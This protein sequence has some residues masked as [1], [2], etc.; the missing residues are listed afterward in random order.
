MAKTALVV[1][2]FDGG[3]STDS[4]F[5][6][7]N[8]FFYSQHL[9]FRK[10]PGQMTVLPK[11]R[12]EAD[13]TVDDLVQNLVMVD[14]STIYGLGNTGLAYKRTTAGVWN[15]IGD[16]DNGA[17]GM[18]YR[19]DVDKLFLAS[20]KTISEYS[21][22]SNSPSIKVNKL[23]ASASTT[24]TRTSGT[25]TY[26]LKTAISESSS[27]RLSFTSDIEPMSSMKV[28]VAAKGTGNWTMTAH[29]E[30]NNTL[31]TSTI[32]NANLINGVLNE[33]TFSSQVRLYVKPNARTYH[34]HLTSTVAD[35][36][37]RC[38]TAGDLNT[39]DY[40]LFA[41]RLV[42][43]NNGMHPIQTFIASEYIGNERYL[44][45]WEPLSETPSNSE[46]NR[47]R[48]TFPPNLEV[49]G[50]AAWNQYLAIACEQKTTGS[51]VPQDGFIYFWD[52]LASSYNYLIRIPEGS[53]YSLHEYK[54]V[55]YY[56][57]GG[58]WYAYAGKAPVKIRTMRSTDS[59]YSDTSDTTIVYPYM[60][61]VRR[62][63]HLL[64][65]PSTTTNQSLQYGVYGYG[66]IDENFPDSFGYSYSI[67]TGTQYNSGGN[68][69]LGTVKNFG[70]LLFISWRDGTSYS[71]DVVDNTSDPFGTASWESLVFEGNYPA[72]TKT[73]L[74]IEGL[75]ETL[76]S[77]VTVTMK[78]K[79]NGAASWTTGGTLTSGTY[80]RLDINQRFYSIQFGFD[81][82]VGT[83]TPVVR[84]VSLVYDDNRKEIFT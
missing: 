32:T 28:L 4:Q 70:D 81:L 80:T 35:G 47:H 31:A 58:A 3:W 50:L 18:S 20:T 10:N 7:P 5:G 65:F 39:A 79:I 66:A 64:G 36:T 25:N 38:S 23:A 74:Y 45:G 8:S 13:S 54:N 68:L 11:T 56:F 2:R 30:A 48:L 43:S 21:P 29:D 44:A 61:T 15:V 24:A 42:A 76:P 73:A 57:A 27:D 41:D 6:I 14:N 9:D 83:T 53:P 69:Q 82:I 60:A 71:V 19:R 51:L 17:F 12:N 1:K 63:I 26:T 62:G 37:V 84:S 78:Y 46:F 59:E 75:F 49:C 67:S 72:K 22:V 55:L 40:T 77:G 34:F 33:F 16:L 52:G